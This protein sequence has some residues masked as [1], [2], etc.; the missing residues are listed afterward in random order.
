[1][2]RL[3]Q[4]RGSIS[5]ADLGLEIGPS[6]N[7]VCPKSEGWNVK[8]LDHADQATL[9]EK[10]KPHKVD[11]SKIEE[12]DFVWNDGPLCES[13]PM[14]LRGKF[15]YI[16]A[17]H[18]IEHQPDVVGFLK[19]LQ[20][21]IADTGKVLLAVPDKRFC[22]DYFRPMQ[23]TGE[24]LS[25]HLTGRTRHSKLTAFS[26]TAYTSR[27]EHGNCW[28]Q[29]Q[30]QDFTLV[31]SRIEDAHVA[32][33]KLDESGV[34]V[35]HHA[36]AF[37]PGSFQLIVLELNALG[38]LELS[39]DTALPAAGCE[40]IVHLRRSLER[41]RDG[42]ELA[43]R[44]KNLLLQHTRDLAECVEFWGSGLR[45]EGAHEAASVSEQETRCEALEKQ[46]TELMGQIDELV[47]STSW[48]ITAPLR[49][50]KRWAGA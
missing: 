11:V 3:T 26:Q 16:I 34:Y 48:R 40:F 25:A 15:H 8:T 28:G 14:G 31:H 6:Y 33:L 4:L 1:M 24:V 2:D 7:P 45:Q 43:A 37:T 29:V 41:E 18:V 27:S 38:Y 42:K 46:I 13:I 32:M 44:R 10:Y 35:D 23:L 22:F 5:K 36:W 20:E 47:H 49:A 39:V 19:S 12:V 17:S 50:L 21:L 30:V 9:R